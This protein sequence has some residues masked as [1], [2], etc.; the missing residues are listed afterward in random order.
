M[1]DYER[2][3]ADYEA[4]GGQLRGSEYN[5]GGTSF[6]APFITNR[7]RDIIEAF[8][9]Y[10]QSR[11]DLVNPFMQNQLAALQGFQG[12]LTP[13]LNQYLGTT[14]QA[15]GNLTGQLGGIG[16][17]YGRGMGD[18]NPFQERAA[19]QQ[20]GYRRQAGLYGL[21]GSSIAGAQERNIARQN[22]REIDAVRAQALGQ[23]A[24]IRAGLEQQRMAGG[25][26]LAGQQYQAQMGAA[27]Q[28]LAAQREAQNAQLAAQTGY[29]TDVLNAGTAAINEIANMGTQGFNMASQMLADDKDLMG[30][31]VNSRNAMLGVLQNMQQQNYASQAANS[32]ILYGLGGAL[33]GMESNPFSGWGP[34]GGNNPQGNLNQNVGRLRPWT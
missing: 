5:P 30:L 11:A 1:A 15:V 34:W 6:Y 24:Q 8:P 20:A 19:Q 9:G 10:Q 25:A 13:S 16:D 21:A 29:G 2:A 33:G 22:Q 12:A 7:Q 23:Q 32:Q 3:M 14:G 4:G 17:V 31:N 27:G 28:Q 18:L 26:G